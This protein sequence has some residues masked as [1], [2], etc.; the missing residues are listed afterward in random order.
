MQ[1]FEL[2]G[3]IRQAANKAV[4]KA[5]RRQGLVPC[6]LYGLGMDNV[7]FTVNAKEL[8]GLTN[9]PKSYIVDLKLDNGQAYTAVLHE[10]Q[11]HPVSDECLHVDFLAVDQVKPIAIM[12]PLV[13]SGHAAGVQRGGKF[14]QIL[15]EVKVSAKMADLPDSI[16][17]DITSLQLD[18]QI[19]A[20]DLQVENVT[21]LTQKGAVICGV[22]STRNSVA[23]APAEEECASSGGKGKRLSIPV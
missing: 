12:V 23:E 4:I 16:P 2:K 13:I 22:K 14:Y 20:G 11:W 18:Q 1:H 21:V 8:K 6:N 9:T 7:L 5:F 15:R 19:K 17:V 10:L 3:Q